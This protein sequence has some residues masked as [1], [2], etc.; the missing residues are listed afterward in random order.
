MIK[1]HDSLLA[2]NGQELARHVL[3]LISKDDL[4][5]VSP[6]G[7]HRGQVISLNVDSP[8]EKRLKNKK[9]LQQ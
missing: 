3:V 7:H 5:L 4:D 2:V 6:G 9:R 1:L 8:E